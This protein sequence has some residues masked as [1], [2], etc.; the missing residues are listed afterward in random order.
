[1]NTLTPEQR[2]RQ[3]QLLETQAR[4]NDCYAQRMAETSAQTGGRLGA[5]ANPSSHNAHLSAAAAKRL[6]AANIRATGKPGK[7]A[8]VAPC[9]SATQ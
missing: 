6:Q 7:W 2:E 4:M 5:D 9:D 8:T 1:M 3:A